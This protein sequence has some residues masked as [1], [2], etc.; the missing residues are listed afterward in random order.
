MKC[1]R[2]TRW[3]ACAILFFGLLTSCSSTSQGGG[4][5]NGGDAGAGADAA[6]GR[7]ASANR[8]ASEAGDASDGSDAGAT[9]ACGKASCARSA[10]YCF[11]EQWNGSYKV[12]PVCRPLPAG[13]STCSCAATDAITL[14]M[15]CK[16]GMFTCID[17]GTVIDETTNPA[18]LTVACN[19]P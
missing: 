5:D 16:T 15:S 4:G 10:Q 8:D 14:T 7:D 17:S 2:S 13:C 18:T 6:T 12:G 9:F 19:I 1:F 3:L 11:V